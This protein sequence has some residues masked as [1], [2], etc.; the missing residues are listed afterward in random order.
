M[1]NATERVINPSGLVHVAL[2]PECSVVV[3]GKAKQKFLAKSR[4]NSVLGEV[5]SSCGQQVL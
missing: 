2:E 1:I 5:T 4:M 3:A